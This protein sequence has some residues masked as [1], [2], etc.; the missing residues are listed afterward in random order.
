MTVTVVDYH[1]RVEKAD[2]A[3]RTT[4]RTTLRTSLRT[5]LNNQPNSFYGVGKY[6]KPTC[7]TELD[8]VFFILAPL[9]TGHLPK[10]SFYNGR[11]VE[12]DW[13][14]KV[15]KD[16][17]GCFSFSYD[18]VGGAGRLLVFFYPVKGIWLID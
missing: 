6:K 10:R 9:F 5:D 17:G 13:V 16:N 1:G 8:P 2:P 15:G 12:K 18:R 4:L 3:P 14:E 7:S 11:S